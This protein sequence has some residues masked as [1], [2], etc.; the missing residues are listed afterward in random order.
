MKMYSY[1]LV[2]FDVR[3]CLKLTV[4]KYNRL[5]HCTLVRVM[6]AFQWLAITSTSQRASMCM[7]VYLL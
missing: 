7:C 3:D 2:W 4:A 5:T 6:C 1:D